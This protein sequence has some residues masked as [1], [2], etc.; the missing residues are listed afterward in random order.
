MLSKEEI[1]ALF[2]KKQYFEVLQGAKDTPELIDYLGFL[3]L[4]SRDYDS[5]EK[6]FSEQKMY[7]QEGLCRILKGDKI[8]ARKLWYSVPED[9]A[10]SWGKVLLGILDQK[11]EAIPTFLQVRNFLESTLNYLFKAGQ[12]DFAHKLIGAKDFFADCNIES[13]KY[14]GRVLMD[15]GYED[16]AFEYFYKSISL[17]P[18]DYEAY[19]HLGELYLRK[20]DLQKAINSYKSVLELNPYHTP[21]EKILKKLINNY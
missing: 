2:E 11:L 12:T 9:I 15:N 1:K 10:I 20:N 17:I 19:F 13:Y 4:E 21:A 16:L 18:Q 5:A 6:F 14:I 7:Y 3:F 8:S